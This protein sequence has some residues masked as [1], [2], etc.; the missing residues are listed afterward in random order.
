MNEW[1]LTNRDVIKN[2]SVNTGTSTDPVFTPLCCTSEIGISTDFNQTDF[3]VFC[4]AIQRHLI[5]GTT[6]SLSA[7]VMM[8]VNNVAIQGLLTKINS[9]ISTGEIAQFN[10]QQIEFELLTGVSEGVLTY[11]KYKA[12]CIMNFSDLGGAAESESSFTLDI[13]I[14]GKAEALVG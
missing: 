8:D 13:Q 7:T 5:T 4:D 2:L 9:L 3:Y 10:N 11:Q 1:F 14:Q 12:N 6:L